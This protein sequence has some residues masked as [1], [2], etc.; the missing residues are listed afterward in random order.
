[1]RIINGKTSTFLI[2]DKYI[3]ME[4]KAM[5]STQAD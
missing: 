1:M 4:K 3:S 2:D 5:A